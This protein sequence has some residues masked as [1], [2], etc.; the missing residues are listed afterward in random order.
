MIF[1]DAYAMT[2]RNVRLR[3]RNPQCDVCGDQPKIVDVKDFDY[4]DF[5]QTNCNKY[6]LIK[7][8]EKNN[9]TVEQFEKDFKEN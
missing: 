5:C 9:I 6:A 3:D 1:F 7:I 2:F 8:P 4:D